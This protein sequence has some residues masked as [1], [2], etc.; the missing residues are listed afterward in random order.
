MPRTQ[1]IKVVRYKTMTLDPKFL[2]DVIAQDDQA[3][4]DYDAWT[5]RR[6]TQQP[7]RKQMDPPMPGENEDDFLDRCLADGEDESTCQNLWDESRAAPK[8]QTAAAMNAER[9][10]GWNDFVKA[11]L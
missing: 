11:H 1:S 6:A 3:R 4:Q 5:R 2:R 10:K 8:S 7:K 9:S